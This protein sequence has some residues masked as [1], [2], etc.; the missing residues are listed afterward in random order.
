MNQ[1]RTTFSQE[2]QDMAREDIVAA[3]HKRGISLRSLSLLNGLAATTLNN[4]LNGPYEKAEEIIASALDLEVK[5]IWPTRVA[6]RAAKESIRNKIVKLQEG[7]CG[8]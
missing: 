7:V 8:S 3:L 2:E 5:D 4:A 6:K 1:S